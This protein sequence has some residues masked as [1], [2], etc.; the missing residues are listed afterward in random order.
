MSDI[1]LF[2]VGF[3]LSWVQERGI[4]IMGWDGR[5]NGVKW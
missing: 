3:E 4:D 2:G 5:R 1:L